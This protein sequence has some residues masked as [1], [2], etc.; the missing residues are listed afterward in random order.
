MNKKK[1]KNQGQKSYIN[2]TTPLVMVIVNL[3]VTAVCIVLDCS[4][5]AYIYGLDTFFCTVLE[6]R[7]TLLSTFMTIWGI[8]ISVT[9]FFAGRLDNLIYGISLKKIISWKLNSILICLIS[10]I[11]CL[12]FPIMLI[13]VLKGWP[14]TLFILLILLFF[15]VVS[16]AV[17][18]LKS[19]DDDK[20]HKL[21]KQRSI[22]DL[23][24][25]LNDMSNDNKTSKHISG[26]TLKN[27]LEELP[28]CILIC[29]A[30]YKNIE[31][32]Q[33][34][35]QLLTEASILII[36]RMVTDRACSTPQFHIILF[37]L[38]EKLVTHSGIKSLTKYRRTQI[39][40]CELLTGITDNKGR[41]KKV[42]QTKGWREAITL[43]SFVIIAA[44]IY[45]YPQDNVGTDINEMLHTLPWEIRPFTIFLLLAFIE[46]LYA[47]GDIN[48]ERLNSF[49]RYIGDVYP[50]ADTDT[51]YIGKIRLYWH[52]WNHYNLGYWKK[53]DSNYLKDFLAEYNK[54][55]IKNNFGK[56]Y[57]MNQIKYGERDTWRAF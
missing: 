48:R 37:P 51:Y 31:D 9:I 28:V 33:L 44:V 47:G 34:V 24:S 13:C 26:H 1:H 8:V 11:Y 20:I 32:K 57:V 49:A 50:I 27:K 43:I 2:K 35:L 53:A 16:F 55:R 12:L 15:D 22:L 3:A 14:I 45:C 18:V 4:H 23:N 6:Y 38:I 5:R 41:E 36:K 29:N 54:I 7:A 19:M 30:N 39:I 25:I 46:Y 40:L 42:I 56:S 21:I 10:A 17:F 52:I